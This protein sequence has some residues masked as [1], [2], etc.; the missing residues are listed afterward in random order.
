MK[1]ITTSEFGGEWIQFG[2]ECFPDW[3]AVIAYLSKKG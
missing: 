3:D 2:S 1:T